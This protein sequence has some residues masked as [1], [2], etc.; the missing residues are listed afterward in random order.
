MLPL[1]LV[2][3]IAVLVACAL[4]YICDTSLLLYGKITAADRIIDQKVVLALIAATAAEL[5][6]IILAAINKL[7]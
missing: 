6:A 7:Q 5:S 4:L 1:F 3:N 2:A